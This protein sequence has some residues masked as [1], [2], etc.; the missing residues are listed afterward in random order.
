MSEKIKKAEKRKN[1][2]SDSAQTQED[3][4]HDHDHAHDH[5]E[6]KTEVYRIHSD[7]TAEKID[8]K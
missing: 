8:Q 6:N 2:K 5:A 7:G 1:G 3:P 4:I